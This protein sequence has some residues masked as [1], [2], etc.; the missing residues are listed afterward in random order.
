MKGGNNGFT[1]TPN[2]TKIELTLSS[3]F[4]SVRITSDRDFCS[5]LVIQSWQDGD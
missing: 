2:V 1:V 4:A 3:R 5:L